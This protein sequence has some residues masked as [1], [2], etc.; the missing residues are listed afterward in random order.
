MDQ[1][2]HSLHLFG[3]QRHAIIGEEHNVPSKMGG[4][5]GRTGVT[6]QDAKLV[7]H[8]TCNTS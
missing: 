4:S 2:I 7:G 3:V 1:I 5:G 6:N 8:S